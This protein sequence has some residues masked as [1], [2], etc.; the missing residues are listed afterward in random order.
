MKIPW[1]KIPWRPILDAIV[2]W[3]KRR[4]WVSPNADTAP[5]VPTADPSP[6]TTRRRTGGST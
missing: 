6:K 1:G 3:L 2:G 5:E 4:G